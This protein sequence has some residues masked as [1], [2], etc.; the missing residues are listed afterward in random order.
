MSTLPVVAAVDGSDDSL[1]ALEWAADAA[2]GGFAG[3]VLGSNSM[4]AARNADCPV[5]VVLRAGREVH[6]EASP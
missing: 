4:A 2:R 3:L 1:R 6:G 5:V